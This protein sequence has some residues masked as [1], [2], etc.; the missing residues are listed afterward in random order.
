[1]NIAILNLTSPD[2]GFDRHG[3]AAELIERWISPAFDEANFSHISVA[4]GEPLPEPLDFDGYILSG[5]EKGVYDDTDWMEPLKTFLQL[6]KTH[7]VPVFGI[8]FGHQIMAEAYG[9]KA[10]KSD[11]GFIVGVHEYEQN[12][13]IFNAH[14]MHQDQVIEVPDG[15]TITASAA[16]CPVAALHYDFP[17]R[18][19][20]FHPEFLKPLVEDAIDLFEGGLLTDSEIDYAR[21]TM[22]TGSVEPSLQATDIAEFF[23]QANS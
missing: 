8:C 2:K 13:E 14:A 5:S 17:A 9:G 11:A 19:V 23:R 21:K 18:S 1:M 20:Q 7:D 12:G 4:N 3:N 15:A 10:E 16:Y 6:V 22:L